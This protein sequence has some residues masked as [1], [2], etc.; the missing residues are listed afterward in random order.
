[1][2]LSTI[3]LAMSYSTGANAI[4]YRRLYDDG[5]NNAF[6][7]ALPRFGKDL[8]GWNRGRNGAIN[9]NR[10]FDDTR[11]QRVPSIQNHLEFMIESGKLEND[12]IIAA[13]QAVQ[14][15]QQRRAPIKMRY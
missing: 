9:V 5:M 3:F 6:A 12:E 10:A 2:K 13:L 15:R 14:E 1:M 11:E 8:T 4:S 7:D